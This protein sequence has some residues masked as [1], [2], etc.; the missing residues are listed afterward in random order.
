[1]SK[2][3]SHGHKHTAECGYDKTLLVIYFSYNATVLIKAL[4]Q[5]FIRKAFLNEHCCLNVMQATVMETVFL[6]S[7]VAHSITSHTAE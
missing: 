5:D 6:M 4:Y 2:Y 1:M 7:A 3:I